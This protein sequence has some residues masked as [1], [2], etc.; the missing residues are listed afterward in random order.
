MKTVTVE[1]TLGTEARK[2]KTVIVGVPD[3]VPDAQVKQEFLRC[4]WWGGPA[5]EVVDVV[6]Y[7]TF[8]AGHRGPH[9]VHG[10]ARPGCNKTIDGAFGE[11]CPDC[12]L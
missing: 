3:G 9:H 10:C 4:C 5:P 8:Q 2:Y 11:R 12:R 1:R 7:Q 6:D